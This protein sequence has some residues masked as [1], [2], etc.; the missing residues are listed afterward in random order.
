VIFA[1]LCLYHSVSVDQF[2]QPT[3]GRKVGKK[4]VRDLAELSLVFGSADTVSVDPNL[5]VVAHPKV[6]EKQLGFLA[7]LEIHRRNSKKGSQNP[8]RLSTLNSNCS[9][10]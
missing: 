4:Q 7:D 3:G 8:A 9:S 6:G 2:R 5:H 1:E 10:R